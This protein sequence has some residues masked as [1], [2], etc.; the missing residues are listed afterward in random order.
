MFLRD[1][2]PSC[3]VRQRPSCWLHWPATSS[4]K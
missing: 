1:D 4:P 3:W 2:M